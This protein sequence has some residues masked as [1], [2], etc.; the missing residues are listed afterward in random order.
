MKFKE[1]FIKM[2]FV[3][4]LASV[5]INLGIISMDSAVTHNEIERTYSC[6]PSYHIVPSDYMFE[7]LNQSASSP[8]A[9]VFQ[10]IF[11]LFFISPPLIVVLLFLIWKELK[12][13]NKLK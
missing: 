10:I 4:L 13:R 6:F 8:L 5:T 11:I 3:F 7:Y 12:E 1:T 2:L 9:F